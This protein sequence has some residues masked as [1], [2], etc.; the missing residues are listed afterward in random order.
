MTIKLYNG[1]N[2][3]K[4]FIG[5]LI[6]MTGLGMGIVTNL[7]TVSELNFSVVRLEFSL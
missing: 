5:K 6:K 4:L 1:G 7:S 3:T 2:V